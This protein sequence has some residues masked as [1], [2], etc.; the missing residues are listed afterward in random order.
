MSL[1]LGTLKT[2]GMTVYQSDG[3]FDL[4][5]VVRSGSQQVTVTRYIEN[6]IGGGPPPCAAAGVPN[7]APTS[8]TTCVP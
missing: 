5:V 2:Q 8:N 1:T 7:S 3:D 4:T 6:T